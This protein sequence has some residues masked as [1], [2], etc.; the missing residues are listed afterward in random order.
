MLTDCELFSCKHYDNYGNQ[1]LK[2]SEIYLSLIKTPLQVKL[3]SQSPFPMSSL[4]VSQ[5]KLAMLIGVT[6]DLLEGGH[7]MWIPIWDKKMEK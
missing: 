1:C 4:K 5:G 7:L 2:I 3:H 6:C